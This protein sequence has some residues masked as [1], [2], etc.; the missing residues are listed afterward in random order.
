[1]T[2]RR[3]IVL[4]SAAAVAAAIALGAV[5]TYVLVRGDLRDELDG[6][7]A[8]THPELAPQPGAEGGATD[9]RVLIRQ[10]QFGGTTGVAQATFDDGKTIPSA[11][12]DTTLPVD[13]AVLEVAAGR[14]G[15]FLRDVTVAGHRLRVL[16][17]SGPDGFALQV[18]RPLDEIDSTLGRLRL[19]LAAVTL[20]GFG[21]AAAL[22]F[23]V[24][25]IATRPLAR[26]TATAERVT[27]TGDLHHRLPTRGG[28]ADD[29]PGRL[30]ASFN[31]MLAA[32]ESSRDQQ[33]QLVAD[34]SHE[35]RTPLTAIRAN[36][37]LLERAPEL[38][39]AER[40]AALGS[41]RGQLED[42]TVLVGDLVD[43][44]RPGGERALEPPEDLRLDELVAAAVRRARRH[45]PGT[46][47]ELAAE[48]CVVRGRR[49][50]LAR[51]VGNLLDN[52]VK[53][54]PPDA[55]IEVAVRDGEVTVRDH[56]PGIAPRDLPHVFDRFYRAPS[57]RGLP[58]SG[59]G[60]AIVKHVADDHRGT[61][62]AERA[63][64]GGT[65]LRLALPA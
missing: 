46:S 9:V 30:A 60:L 52:A 59:L 62:A 29:E 49:P 5:L 33:R 10:D 4:V 63:P 6:R 65:L 26:L 53:W 61:V 21:L 14:R 41:A 47:F 17:R 48:P 35:L 50:G 51:A 44:A 18:A 13:D 12:P 31:A 19:I 45:A 38:P 64:G 15:P 57:A 36:I 25:R 3:R 8:Q 43:L 39:D 23:G 55:P 56:G 16:T 40:S 58:G 54:S 1:M 32:L 34:A 7:L 27:A 42:L 37:E 22:G 24:S 28:R 20:G 11:E 2:F